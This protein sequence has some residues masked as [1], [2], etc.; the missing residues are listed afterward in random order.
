MTYNMQVPMFTFSDMCKPRTLVTN[1]SPCKRITQSTPELFFNMQEITQELYD[2]RQEVK[3]LRQINCINTTIMN[4][5]NDINEYAV[6]QSLNDLIDSLESSHTYS[7]S[8]DDEDLKCKSKACKDAVTIA[9]KACKDINR[10]VNKR[11]I[12][13]KP[14]EESIDEEK[15][16]S[17][18]IVSNNKATTIDMTFEERIINSHAKIAEMRT[19][20]GNQTKLLKHKA[21][22][23]NTDADE[24]EDWVKTLRDLTK[25]VNEVQNKQQLSTTPDEIFI[26]D[27]ICLVGIIEAKVK[28]KYQMLTELIADAKELVITDRMMNTESKYRSL[29]NGGMY[30]WKFRLNGKQY[31]MRETYEGKLCVVGRIYPCDGVWNIE[32]FDHRIL[33]SEFM[34]QNPPINV[35]PIVNTSTTIST[36]ENV[37]KNNKSQPTFESNEFNDCPFDEKQIM[38]TFTWKND[39][40][41]SVKNTSK[42]LETPS[43][44][45]PKHIMHHIASDYKGSVFRLVITEDIGS[46]I[47]SQP[48]SD[49]LVHKIHYYRMEKKSNHRYLFIDNKSKWDWSPKKHISMLKDLHGIDEITLHGC[50]IKQ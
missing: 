15:V 22:R 26:K 37:V 40:E 19:T 30:Y 49:Q 8:E 27:Q 9:H 23:N 28:R 21:V 38:L 35:E 34:I 48:S 4:D 47:G 44:V 14:K 2:L 24:Y 33:H 18:I 7:E 45:K 17:V 11:L 10:I 46:S 31:A 3:R 36:I 16:K 50:R 12:F 25:E 5:S 42:F 43:F 32:V 41:R 29:E 13:F 1:P 6:K 20:L 39:F